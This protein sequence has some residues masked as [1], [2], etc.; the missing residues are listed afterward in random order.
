MVH[1]AYFLGL[2]AAEISTITLDEISFG[3]GELS[4]T[5]RKSNNPITVPLPEPTL[6]AIVAY[7]I[8]GR[9]RS[10]S[11]RLFLNLCP[12]Y[13]PITPAAVGHA[14]R[15]CMKRAGL[16]ATP[17]WLRHTYAQ[18]LLEAG[19]SIYEIKEMLGHDSIESSRAYLHIHTTLMREVLFDESL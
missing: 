2:R 13:R 8:G 9:A 3:K 18:N 16:R 1:L 10:T 15:A 12:P 17:Y 5:D 11:R 14:I 6:K 7:L 4:L 19:A